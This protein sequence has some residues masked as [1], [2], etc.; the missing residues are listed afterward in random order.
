MLLK[1]ICVVLWLKEKSMTLFLRVFVS[2]DDANYRE[3]T[4]VV[5]NSSWIVRYRNIFLIIVKYLLIT[6]SDCSAKGLT[7][8]CLGIYL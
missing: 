3:M 7:F 4:G 8:P 2:C 6:G 1:N 5:T